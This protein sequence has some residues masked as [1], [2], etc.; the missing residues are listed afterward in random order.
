M[1]R[2]LAAVVSGQ[3]LEL[4]EPVDQAKV[5]VEVVDEQGR[6]VSDVR[7]AR[8]LGGSTMLSFMSGSYTRDTMPGV[9]PRFMPPAAG[10][11]MVPTR[12]CP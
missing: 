7:I 4:S 12:H 10:R 3:N 2:S 1:S 5:T 8:F 6:P 9:L 11:T